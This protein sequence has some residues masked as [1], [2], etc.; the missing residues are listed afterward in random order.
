MTA[1]KTEGQCRD[2]GLTLG[3]QPTKS[4]LDFA[5]N[6]PSGYANIAAA[7][8]VKGYALH[9]LSDGCLL[10]ERWGYSRTFD[11]LTQAAQFLTLIGGA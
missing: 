3:E 9:R 6:L 10:I 2:N 4:T 11:T 1:K 5:S 7:L 8:A